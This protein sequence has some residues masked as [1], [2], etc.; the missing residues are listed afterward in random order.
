MSASVSK[1]FQT[2][3]CPL[4]YIFS[5]ISIVWGRQNWIVTAEEYLL[6]VSLQKML[7]GAHPAFQF[8]SN[9]YLIVNIPQRRCR[10]I[11]PGCARASILWV[12][13]GFFSLQELHTVYIYAHCTGRDLLTAWKHLQLHLHLTF[14]LL[15]EFC[16]VAFLH[17]IE[18]ITIVLMPLYWTESF[19]SSPFP[20]E[21]STVSLNEH[22]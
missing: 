4:V 3:P 2:L 11:Y 9:L 12:P 14:F 22:Q 15:V 7:A 13:W 16:V 8:I 18:Y 1:A 10:H 5:V 19:Q 21:G 17:C 6:F 20:S